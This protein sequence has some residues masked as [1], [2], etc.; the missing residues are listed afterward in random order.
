MEV[1]RVENLVKDYG[2]VRAVK[3]LSFSLASGEIVGLLG[4]N[5]AGK[6]TTIEML[7][8]ILEPTSGSI[9]VLG[10]PLET[11][12]YEVVQQMNFAAPYALLPGNLSVKENLM[13][14]ALLY[15]V[16]NARRRVSELLGQ[17]ELESL[18]S[19]RT[20]LLS[21][22]EQSRLN[23]AKAFINAPTLLLLDEPTASLD[24]DA[25]ARMRQRITTEARKRGTAILWTSHNMYEMETVCDRILFLFQGRIVAE[26]TPKELVQKFG[27]EDLE[28]TF[29]ALARG[30]FAAE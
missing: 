7:L 20:G 25:A 30:F 15:G 17:F 2:K 22:G 18:A 13:I 5:G 27:K 6:T 8:G 3:G 19:V 28:Q 24:P 16:P 9:E 4:P 1:L 10:R 29:I 11:H 14:F 12:R 21:S 23:L 26:G